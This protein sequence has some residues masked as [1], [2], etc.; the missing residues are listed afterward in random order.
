MQ[1]TRRLGPLWQTAAGMMT[2]TL[3]GPATHHFRTLA[4]CVPRNDNLRRLGG[5]LAVDELVEVKVCFL[6]VLRESFTLGIIPLSWLGI[7]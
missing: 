5:V 1:E 7:Q 4:R 6:G 3:Y 2:V